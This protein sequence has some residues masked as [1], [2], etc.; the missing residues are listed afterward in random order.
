MQIKMR[1]MAKI[2]VTKN[3]ALPKLYWTMDRWWI[4]L[5]SLAFPAIITVFYLMIFK[6]DF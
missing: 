3:V 5:G 6:P 4:F 2:S 1:D